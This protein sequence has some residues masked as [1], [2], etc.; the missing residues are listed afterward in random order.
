MPTKFVGSASDEYKT[1][2]SIIYDE[3]G[4]FNFNLEKPNKLMDSYGLGL[5]LIDKIPPVI[6]G[7]EDL[8]FFENPNAGTPYDKSLLTYSAY[9]ER[10]GE[11][12]DL[13]S[14][15]V[16]TDWGGFNPDDITA[17]TF[18]KNKPYTIT[19]TVKDKVG[20]TTSVRRKIT[21]VGLFDTMVRV[22]G[23]YPDSSGRVE[24]IGDTVEIGLENFSGTAYARYEKGI[25]TMGEMKHIGT[26]IQ[27]NDGKFKLEKLSEGWYTFYVQTDLRDY[28][29]INVYIYSK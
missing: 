10:Y 18:N 21:L 19:Y 20:N 15:V 11:K 25:H 13:T 8:M 22:N 23:V 7:V 26:V 1:A 9:D 3:D 6:E 4:W 2:N 17:N 29:C 16:V 28:F 14:E 5:Y 12:T 24:I 27:Q